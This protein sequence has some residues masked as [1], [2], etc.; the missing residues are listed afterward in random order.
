M[1]IK[2]KYI[3]LIINIV[4]LTITLVAFSC[5]TEEEQLETQYKP[6]T[7]TT[8]TPT[9]VSYNSITLGGRITAPQ[10]R[11]VQRG[12]CWSTIPN[13]NSE[14]SYSK[15]T[16]ETGIGNFSTTITGLSAGTKYYIKA[17]AKAVKMAVKRDINNN[18]LPSTKGIL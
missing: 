8:N 9:S 12:F 3:N 15:T 5:L 7:V 4:L 1:K 6:V 16:E 2:Y 17:F 11:N 13:E 14:Q 10:E 18:S